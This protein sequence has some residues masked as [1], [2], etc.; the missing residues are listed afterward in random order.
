MFIRVFFMYMYCVLVL[1]Y[2]FKDSLAGD[3]V[4]IFIFASEL[5]FS[6]RVVR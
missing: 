3:I 6:V 4:F 1:G 2:F 5:L